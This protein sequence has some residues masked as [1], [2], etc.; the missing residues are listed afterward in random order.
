MLVQVRV[1][2]QIV[3]E[4]KGSCEKGDENGELNR[5]GMR[6]VPVELPDGATRNFYGKDLFRT[7]RMSDE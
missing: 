1:Q 7:S 4:S 3:E 5:K 6:L 2:V